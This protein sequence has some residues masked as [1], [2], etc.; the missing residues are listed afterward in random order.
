MPSSLTSAYET[1]SISSAPG[2]QLGR[3]L[4]FQYSLTLSSTPTT[5][6]LERSHHAKAWAIRAVFATPNE[7]TPAFKTVPRK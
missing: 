3:A 6:T 4:L 7:G 1:F 5:R 2:S